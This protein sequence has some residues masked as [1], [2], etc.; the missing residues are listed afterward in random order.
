M[1]TLHGHNVVVAMDRREC[2]IICENAFPAAAAGGPYAPHT[3]RTIEFVVYGNGRMR[4]ELRCNGVLSN[5]LFNRDACGERQCTH[6][7]AWMH[8][9][10]CE[11]AISFGKMGATAANVIDGSSH[12]HIRS[13][14]RTSY[15][16]M[17]FRN[18][19]FKTRLEIAL[20]R[21]MACAHTRHTHTSAPMNAQNTGSLPP[22]FE[23][24]AHSV[25][26]ILRKVIIAAEPSRES[27]EAIHRLGH[28]RIQ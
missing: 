24:F 21:R 3:L 16:E 6:S 25:W 12:T 19:N 11:N 1:R 5:L 13:F 4:A 10:R 9:F 15:G 8:G 20:R 2:K 7:P 14:V 26:P 23:S 27:E 18:V 28:F 17:H 22:S